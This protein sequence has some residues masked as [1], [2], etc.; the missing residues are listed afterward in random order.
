MPDMPV[1]RSQRFIPI[2]HHSQPSSLLPWATEQRRDRCIFLRLFPNTFQSIPRTTR[3]LMIK[4]FLQNTYFEHVSLITWIRFGILF[5]NVSILLMSCIISLNLIRID[6]FR[7]ST[8]VDL[9]WSNVWAIF[10]SIK[11]QF[12]NSAVWR[13]WL[14]QFSYFEKFNG[15]VILKKKH[16]QN[17]W[18]RVNE[19][20]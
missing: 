16:I 5:W 1:W 18:V 10:I 17:N 7:I 20:V 3:L 14:V 12:K 6:I 11:K 13:D 15:R 9:S 2:G 4:V 19:Q 8:L